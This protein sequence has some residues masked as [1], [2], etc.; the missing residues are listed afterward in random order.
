MAQL[1]C[2]NCESYKVK[3]DPY[4]GKKRNG[5][6]LYIIAFVTLLTTLGID[7]PLVPEMDFRGLIGEQWGSMLN[8]W[9]M[10]ACII[11]GTALLITPWQDNSE[12]NAAEFTCEN[13]GRKWKLTVAQ[14]KQFEA[15]PE[16]WDQ[17]Q[18]YVTVVSHDEPQT[19]VQYTLFDEEQRIQQEAEER[20]KEQQLH[21]QEEQRQQEAQRIRDEQRMLEEQNAFDEQQRAKEEQERELRFNQERQEKLE[22]LAVQINEIQAQIRHQLTATN[23]KEKSYSTLVNLRKQEQELQTRLVAAGKLNYQDTLENSQPTKATSNAGATIGCLAVV[24]VA[25]FVIAAMMG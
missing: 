4:S 25:I 6:L 13:C 2:P 16:D 22:S 10:W 20:L 8:T 12:N 19:P 21:A 17:K 18:V 15:L 14:Y 9:F 1:K 3:G 24:V 7:L 5:C 23:P 11:G